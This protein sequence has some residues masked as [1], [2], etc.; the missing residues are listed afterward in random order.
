MEAIISE[1]CLSLFNDVAGYAPTFIDEEK[2]SPLLGICHSVAFTAVKPVVEGRISSDN[3]AFKSRYGFFYLIHSDAFTALVEDLF[4]SS[5]IL[6][7]GAHDIQDRLMIF[8]SHLDG[9][10]EG[11]LR[12]VLQIG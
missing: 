8:Q 11:V 10:D 5:N 4:E 1:Q 9:I 7:I 6:R 3:G 12:L 2:I